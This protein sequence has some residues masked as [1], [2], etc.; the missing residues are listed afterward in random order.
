MELIKNGRVIHRDFP[1]DKPV[2][3]S[4]WDKPLI[5]RIEF[6]WGPWASLEMAR[7]CDWEMK[8]E[9]KGGKILEF[10]PCF[11]SGPLEEERRNRVTLRG[12]NALEIVSYTSRR[13]A[14]AEK[15]TNA[16]VLKVQA[17][18]EALLTIETKRPSGKVIEKKLK[19]LLETNEV[20]F[21]GPFPDESI[22]IHRPVPQVRAH[23][24]FT[25]TDE[26]GGDTADWYY[27]RATQTNGQLAWSS[28]IWV[29]KRA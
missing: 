25:L 15:P 20:I 26:S 24:S 16:V 3:D 9:L 2:K 13:Q 10:Q 7:V 6:G 21:T 28:P 1:V 27:L 8:I 19:E 18:P 23:S 29:E 5:V 11:Q 4:L 12:E 22:L 14:F 17:G